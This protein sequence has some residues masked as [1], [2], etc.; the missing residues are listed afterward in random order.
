MTISPP[1]FPTV[2]VTVV[3][4]RKIR[5]ARRTNHIARFVTVSSW[6]KIRAITPGA[7]QRSSYWTQS[8]HCH[9]H[10]QLAILQPG[11]VLTGALDTT[12]PVLQWADTHQWLTTHFNGTKSP[13]SQPSSQRSGQRRLPATSSHFPFASRRPGLCEVWP[14]QV[15]RPWP[16]YHC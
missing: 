6:K 9:C 11:P 10:A 13:S 3:R 15:K 5:T 14:R 16:R 12:E 8:C 4:D 1:L 7:Q 2:T